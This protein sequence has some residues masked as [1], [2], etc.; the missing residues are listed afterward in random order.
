M[1]K[2]LKA[3]GGEVPVPLD[4]RKVRQQMTAAFAIPRPLSGIGS[5]GG[6]VVGVG[7]ELFAR[8]A[9]GELGQAEGLLECMKRLID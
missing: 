9:G 7:V 5:R 1:S 4:A 3:K 2:Q 8:K 6:V